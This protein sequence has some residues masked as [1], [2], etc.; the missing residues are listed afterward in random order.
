MDICVRKPEFELRDDLRRLVFDDRV[1]SDVVSGGGEGGD[2]SLAAFVGFFRARVGDGE[3]GAACDLPFGFFAVFVGGLR[4]IFS[5][6][7]S[8]YGPI[9]S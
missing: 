1:I 5:A 6:D 9:A 3:H 8:P 2:D 7:H 4:H